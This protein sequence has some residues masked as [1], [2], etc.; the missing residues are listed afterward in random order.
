MLVNLRRIHVYR[1]VLGYVRL[2]AGLF[3]KLSESKFNE[4]RFTPVS[5]PTVSS[6][7]DRFRSDVGQP[8]NIQLDS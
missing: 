8:H 3:F 4:F 7:D 2:G 6:G 5:W 1:L